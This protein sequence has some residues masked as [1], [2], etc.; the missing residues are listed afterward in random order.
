MRE[1]A[2]FNAYSAAGKKQRQ[3]KGIGMEKNTH[4]AWAEIDLGAIA[5]NFREIQRKVGGARVLCVIKANAY[6]HGSVP[7]ARLLQAEGAAYFG[8]ATVPEAVE[9]RE[10]GITLPIL[11]LGYVDEADAPLV[12]RYGITA[13][14][15]D[16]DTARMLS[17]AATAEGRAIAVHF[18]VDS[19]MT[20]LG[21]DE[22]GRAHV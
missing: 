2:C 11:I 12:A 8:V 5:H 15:Y 7:V 9:L 21:F 19:G 10:Q 13:A 6:G 14:V 20:R 16:W 18:K 3:D 22:I 4:R 1:N 17:D